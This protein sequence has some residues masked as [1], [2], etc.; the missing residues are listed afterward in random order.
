MQLNNIVMKKFL[1]L[2]AAVSLMISCS[3]PKG[4]VKI[5]TNDKEKAERDSSTKEDS[6]EYELIVL[7][8]GFESWYILQDSPARYRSQQYYEEWNR[9]YVSAWNYNAGQPGRRSFF[10][11]IIG[12][13]PF[14]DYGF[15]L[16]HKLFYY[17]QYVEQVLKIPIL[18]NRP[19]AV[20]F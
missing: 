13:E 16:N 5:E 18:S 9:Q 6:V 19:A 15:E 20:V 8:V 12:Y 10:Q 14:E 3:S 2:F 7:D 11:S 1:F 4:V 17:F